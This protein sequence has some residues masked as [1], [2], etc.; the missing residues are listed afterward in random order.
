MAGWGLTLL[1]KCGQLFMVL[2]S[3][4]HWVA[5]VVVTLLYTCAV[6]EVIFDH[7]AL[8]MTRSTSVST[9]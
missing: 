1:E 8:Q 3:R 6:F 9:T 4:V 2:K 5:E 7:G